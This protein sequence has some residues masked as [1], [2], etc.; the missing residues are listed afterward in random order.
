MQ[1]SLLSL[2]L[3]LGILMPFPAAA[4]APAIPEALTLSF[5]PSHPRPYDHVTVTVGSTLVNLAASDIAISV[6]GAVIEEGVRSATF[7]LGGPGSRSVVRASATTPE[8]TQTAQ[9]TLRPADLSLIVEPNATAHPFYDGGL[10][11]PSEGKLRIIALA[12]LRSAPGTR[13]SDKDISYL[14]KVDERQLSAESGFGKNVLTASAPPRYRD[15]K[16]TV[17]ATSREGSVVAEASV[18]ISPTDPVLRLYAADPLSGTNFAVALMDTFGFSG[19]E[20]AF[21]AVPYFF[22]DAPS[23]SWRLNGNPSGAKDSITVRSSGGSGSAVLSA[24]ASLPGA[25]AGESVTLRFENTGGGGF[26]GL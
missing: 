20:A 11:V 8:G 16:V 13:I 22:K 5:T 18:S 7:R 19:S 23:Y 25:R 26:F 4:Q 2:A 3:L 10:L 24:E 17:T 15:T 14:W 1:R 9:K 21:R 12:D 6:D